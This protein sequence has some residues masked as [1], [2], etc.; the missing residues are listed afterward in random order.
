MDVSITGLYNSPAIVVSTNDHSMLRLNRVVFTDQ[1][2]CGI[3]TQA[4][5][6]TTVGVP[7]V[8]QPDCVL[9]AGF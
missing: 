6:E 7:G 3:L 4:H 2:Y 1:R 8:A 9:T 5:L